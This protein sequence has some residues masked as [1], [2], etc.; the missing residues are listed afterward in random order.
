MATKIL[1][2]SADS[3]I[4]ENLDFMLRE[5][6]KFLQVFSCTDSAKALVC[7]QQHSDICCVLGDEQFLQ[8]VS[9]HGVLKICLSE[10]TLLQG[11]VSLNIYQRK[12]NILED[13]RRILNL[14]DLLAARS[15]PKE[16]NVISFFSTQGGSGKSTLA[17]ACAVESAKERK[18]CYINFEVSPATSGFYNCAWEISSEDYLYA[19]KEHEI[20][21]EL[22]VKILVRNQ[23]NVYVLPMPNSV[24]DRNQLD[25]E[26]VHFLIQTLLTNAQI[27]CVIVDLPSCFD[28]VTNQVMEESKRVVLIY[29]DTAEG[30]EK[31]NCL[32]SDLAFD[33]LPCAGKEFVVKNFCRER[34]DASNCKLQIAYSNNLWQKQPIPVVLGLVPEFSQGCKAILQI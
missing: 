22:L 31:C 24:L 10:E 20:P 27:E 33:S 3:Y 2:Y 28:G 19:V 30:K 29:S 26:D 13:L 23:D 32:L 14:Y 8:E 4:G 11:N 5:Q 18:T 15:V 12:Q 25:S 1:L 17:Y 34:A 7:L 9:S 16:Q 21:K 6:M